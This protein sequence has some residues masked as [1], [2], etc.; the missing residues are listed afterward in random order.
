MIL[1]HRTDP[2]IGRSGQGLKFCK[3]FSSRFAAKKTIEV[4]SI[5]I[6][7]GSQISWLLLVLCN[8]HDFFDDIPE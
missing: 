4:N 7:F 2:C 8:K 6:P 5:L 1:T 3:V